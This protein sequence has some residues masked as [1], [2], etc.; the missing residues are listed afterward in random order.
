[1]PLSPGSG[2]FL[3]S[4]SAVVDDVGVTWPEPTGDTVLITGEDV[5]EFESFFLEDLLESLA[6][7]SCSCC[8]S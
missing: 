7:E 5:P 8:V 6:R 4:T 3:P 2:L 1:M